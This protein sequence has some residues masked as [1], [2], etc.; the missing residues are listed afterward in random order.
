MA[1]STTLSLVDR[2]IPG[3]VRNFLTL[4][5]ENGDS[6]TA[7]SLRLA[8]EHD[9]CVTHATVRNW[10]RRLEV[11]EGEPRLVQPGARS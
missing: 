7:I 9:I 10:C 2:I 3:G 6:Y 1:S 11:P 8:R 4:A 5:R